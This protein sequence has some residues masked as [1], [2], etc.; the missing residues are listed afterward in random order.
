MPVGIGCKSRPLSTRR[1]KRQRVPTPVVL[2]GRRVSVAICNVR[3]QAFC[4]V[5]KLETQGSCQSLDRPQMPA[6]CVEDVCFTAI[7]RRDHSLRRPETRQR[8]RDATQ[9]ITPCLRDDEASV[10]RNGN[11]RWF[12]QKA[13]R[14][15]SAIAKLCG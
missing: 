13:V 11:S 8:F 14:R 1:D 2:D 5:G 15:R 6:L 3:E 12:V 4:I 10:G 9:P 7:L